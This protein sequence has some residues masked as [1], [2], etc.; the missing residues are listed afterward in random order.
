MEASTPS[1]L[2][3]GQQLCEVLPWA[4]AQVRRSF[5][6]IWA[7]EKGRARGPCSEYHWGTGGVTEAWV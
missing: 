7:E 5:E 1:S 6:T 4:E 2:C 3:C